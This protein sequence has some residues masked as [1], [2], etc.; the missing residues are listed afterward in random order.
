MNTTKQCIDSLQFQVYILQ[1][2]LQEGITK[3]L[4]R[5]L[6]LEKYQGKVDLD[7]YHHSYY[8]HYSYS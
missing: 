5:I 8:H 6:K 3:Y 4:G 2:L 7:V 1:A